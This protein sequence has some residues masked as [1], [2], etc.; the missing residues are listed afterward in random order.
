MSRKIIAILRGITPEEVSGVAEALIAGGI[1]R[2]EVPLNVPGAWDSIRLLVQGA[3]R[4]ALVGAGTVLAPEEVMRLAHMGA[5]LAVSPDM[6]QRVIMAAKK[7]GMVSVPGI[8]TPTEAFT[9]LRTGADA[10]KLFP[11][12]LVGPAG[13]AALKTVLPEGTEVYPTGGVSAENMADWARAGAAGFGIG[14]WLYAPG[15][16]AAEVAARARDVVAAYDAAMA[17]AGGA[18]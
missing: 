15:R 1:G 16:P 6:N 12:P 7:A 10:L 9:A 2:I 11:A 5:R 8:M 18:R 14:G 13:L 4:D 17:G 3:G